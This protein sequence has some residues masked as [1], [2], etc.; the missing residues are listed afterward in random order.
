MM[1]N[2][3]IRGYIIRML[4]ASA[5][6]TL[7]CHQI[8]R[9][10]IEDKLAGSS[11]ISKHLDYLHQKGYIQFAGKHT[12]MTVTVEDGPVSLTAAGVDLVEGSIEDPG[13]DI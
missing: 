10:L 5:Q 4:A 8:S 2:K 1:D 7:L 6:N 3:T 9:K 12:A 11:D 13:V